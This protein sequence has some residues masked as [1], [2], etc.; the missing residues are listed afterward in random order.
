MPLK[1]LW[2]I[3]FFPSTFSM[4]SPP[5]LSIPGITSVLAQ[6]IIAL[7]YR[8]LAFDSLLLM[9]LNLQSFILPWNGSES[10]PIRLLFSSSLNYSPI[11]FCFSL[12]F[13]ASQGFVDV[14][15]RL[16]SHWVEGNPVSIWET[17][18]KKLK[19]E[20]KK[21]PKENVEKF[22]SC[23]IILSIIGIT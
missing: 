21:R 2:R 17:K 22:N 14:V 13:L 18:I 5:D 1:K 20:I 19:N 4:S 11:H 23:F 3:Y 16:W 6:A 12:L 10:C 15:K 9:N 7:L 8:F